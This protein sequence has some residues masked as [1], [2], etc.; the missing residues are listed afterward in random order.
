MC[1]HV[2]PAL[3]FAALRVGYALAHPVV[4]RLLS[5]VKVPWNVA[6]IVLAVDLGA[7]HATVALADL[8]GHILTSHTHE[9]VIA[10]GPKPVLDAV[11][12]AQAKLVSQWLLIGFIHGVMNTDNMSIAG[13][14]IEEAARREV[15][16]RHGD[17][18]DGGARGDAKAT[19]DPFGHR[20]KMIDGRK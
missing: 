11:I 19:D 17:A 1:G 13:E 7:T 3:A 8:A 16:D 2:R 20:H 12:A 15:F 10:D 18:H 5:R 9:I 4:V 14:T 6:G